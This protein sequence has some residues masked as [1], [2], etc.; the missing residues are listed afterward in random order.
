VTNKWRKGCN[1]NKYHR[2]FTLIEL[3][4]VITIIAILAAAAL[5]RFIDA[6]RDARIAKTN[7]IYGS[8]RSASVLAKARCELDLV[9]SAPAV[10]CKTVTGGPGVVMD[11][12]TVAMVYGYPAGTNATAAAGIGTAAQINL[13]ADGLTQAASGTGVRY[14]TNGGTAGQCSVGYAPA[15]FSGTQVA[16]VISVITTNC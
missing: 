14:D 4:I 2:G 11:G 10:N 8:I 1:V 6:Q 15:T 5:P 16:P 7:A 13:V 3:I 9:L 12:A